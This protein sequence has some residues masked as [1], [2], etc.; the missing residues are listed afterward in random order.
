MFKGL[1][2]LKN[3]IEQAKNLQENANKM[4]AELESK[5]VSAS[6]GAGMVTVTVTGSGKFK[7]IIIDKSIINPDDVEMLQDLVLSAVNSGIKKSKE[8]VQEEMSKLTGGMPIPS[9]FDG[10]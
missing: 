4:K 7:E 9:G 3:L 5:E 2:D 8:L 10:L 1:G 6:S